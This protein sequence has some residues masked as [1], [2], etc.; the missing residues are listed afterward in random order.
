MKERNEKLMNI[1]WLRPAYHRH[2]SFGARW[3]SSSTNKKTAAAT[4]TAA[5]FLLL[6]VIFVASFS[7]FRGWVDLESSLSLS[8]KKES[9]E[10]FDFPISLDCVAWKNTSTCAAGKYPTRS[11]YLNFSEMAAP[12]PA[13]CPEYFRWIHEDLKRWKGTGITREMVEKVRRNAHFRLVISG[14]KMYVEKYR[15]SIQTR[16]LF[17][18]WGIM[19][20]L[21]WYP[22]Q[23][24]D[25]E[26]MF[27]CDDRPV[28]RA[29]DYQRPDSGPP[30]LFRYCSDG[31]SLDIVFPDWSFWG[32]AEINIK[33]WR[34]VMKD[35]KE[36]NKKTKW[37]DRV[38]MAYWKGNPHVTPNRA[39]L[40]KCNLTQQHNWNTLL[41]VQDW[42]E[43]SKNGYKQSNL[44]DQCTHRYK[45]YI[46]GWAWSV[47]EKYI[48]SCD[49]PTLYVTPRYHDFFIR[50]MIPQQ[51]YW[52]IRDND[53]CKSLQFAVDWGN[54]HTDKAQAIGEA[55]SH[56]MQEDMKMENIFDFMF[57][58]LSEYAKL[59]RFKPE[60]PQNAVEV[61][62]ES[63]AC[64]AD[65][66]WRK[67]MEESL[68]Q[69]PSNTAPCTLPPPYDPQQLGAFL[70]KKIRATK[71]VEAW[72]NEY[73]S[74][75]LIISCVDLK[76]RNNNGVLTFLLILWGA[77]QRNSNSVF[78]GVSCSTECPE[79]T[80]LVP[81]A[82]QSSVAEACP[83]YFRWIHEDLKPWKARGITREMVEKAREVAHIRVLVVSGV[84]YV[85]KFKQVFQ[86]RDMVTLWGILQLLTLYPGRVPDLDMMFELGDMP[87]IKKKAYRAAAPPPLFHYC[88]DSS[89]H[90]IVF[91]DWSFWG[92]P[93]LKIRPWEVL[94]KELQETNEGRKWEDR[95]PFAY[96]KGN[97]KLSL[98]RRDLVNC[99]A[100]D[101]KEEWNARIYDMDWHREKK[102]G[103]NTSDLVNQCT[104]RYKI[105]VEGISWSVSQKYILACDSM[106]LVINP[107]YYD[108]FT[109]SLIPT[110]HFWPI[111]EKNKCRAIKYAVDW[112]NAHPKQAKGIGRAGSQ[113]VQEKLIMK[114]VYDYMFHLLQEYAKLLRYQPSV[115]EGAVEVCYEALICSVKGL[116][117]RYRLSSMVNNASESGPC[118]LPLPSNRQNLRAFLL[119]KRDLIRQ[120]ELR[121]AANENSRQAQL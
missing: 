48:L 106:S 55:G 98:A 38:P 112:G 21:R 16:A 34:S 118:S 32:W 35:I 73:W 58:L 57:H 79:R 44:E 74:N 52:P 77:F 60:I 93:E 26:L 75:V 53:K 67:F 39:D 9:D 120:V 29:K 12:A 47:S 19:Q 115:P 64:S 91:P 109:R 8:G 117:K 121:E 41:Y 104:H 107:H 80:V 2:Q 11:S 62:P 46:E 31:D 86:T 30:P 82:A 10:V 36:G 119:K 76:L 116:R 20:L 72:E 50:G 85:E 13:K 56:F 78:P 42:N 14:G 61:C 27:D 37:K 113:Y 103:F 54:N 87:V 59:L 90:D 43:E 1:F 99:N 102:Q 96:W 84:L 6:A 4:L 69:S 111:S 68:E 94:K 81:E 24:P 92:W 3:R 70:D 51:H 18:M 83:E 33:P 114:Y 97:T 17:T 49:S 66:P 5:L 105:Y 108:F 40:L 28:V 110:I 101:N 88:G 45:I 15:E 25:L 95:E 71:Q 7:T 22:G 23:L 100:T 65:G 89:S 63:L